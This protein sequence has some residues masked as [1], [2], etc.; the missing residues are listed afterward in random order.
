M[1]ANCLMSEEL[2]RVVNTKFLGASDKW[3]NFST[4]IMFYG[5]CLAWKICLLKALKL[6]WDKLNDGYLLNM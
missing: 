5:M 2:L 6:Y 4:K 1:M 3:N